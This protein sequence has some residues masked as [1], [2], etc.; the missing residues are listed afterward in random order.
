MKSLR[1]S[2]SANSASNMPWKPVERQSLRRPS[3]ISA[4]TGAPVK[5]MPGPLPRGRCRIF[6]QPMVTKISP[7]GSQNPSTV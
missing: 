4:G 1:P 2:L 3:W 5:M 7:V 6:T